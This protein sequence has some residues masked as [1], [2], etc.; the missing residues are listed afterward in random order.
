VMV[1]DARVS[2]MVGPGVTFGLVV[3]GRLVGV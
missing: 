2:A 3:V 1:G